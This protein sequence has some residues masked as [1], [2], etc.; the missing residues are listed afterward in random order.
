MRRV[1]CRLEF[2]A[3][4]TSQL[5]KTSINADIDRGEAECTPPL[6]PMRSVREPFGR[7]ILMSL[8]DGSPDGS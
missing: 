4:L 6:A 2:E 7:L 1:A 3:V 5:M 8:N